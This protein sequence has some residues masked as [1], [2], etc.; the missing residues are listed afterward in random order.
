MRGWKELFQDH[1]FARGE[2][3]FC[4]G[5]VLELHK[6]EQ[7]YHAVV[8]GTE[9]YE[10]DIEIEGGQVHEMYCSCPYAED[11]NNCKHMA[12][13]LY[14]IEEEEGILTEKNRLDQQEE[15]LEKFRYLQP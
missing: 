4:D 1:I 9:D 13:V 7:G 3:Y 15:D 14:M 10:V 6:T 8:E 5:A 2:M 11:G 12:A